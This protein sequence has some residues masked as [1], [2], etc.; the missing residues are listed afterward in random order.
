M[1]PLRII[2]AIEISHVIHEIACISVHLVRN[3]N[4]SKLYSY[5]C[6]KSC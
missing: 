3:H 6:P 5:P 2:M 4:Y 1:H